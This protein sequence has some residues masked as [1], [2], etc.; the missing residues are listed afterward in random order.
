[1]PWNDRTKRRLKLRDLDILMA[2]IN[3]GS[4][5]KA[6]DRLNLSQPAVSKAMAELEAAVGVQLLD[7]S[8]RGVV[9]TTFGVAL[10]KRSIA[11]FNDLRQGVQEIDFLSDPTKG[12]EI[13]IGTTDPIMAAIVSPVIDRL[14]RKY[15]QMFFHIV[16]GDTATLYRDVTERHIEVA[17]CRMIGRLPDELAAEI[18]FYD[19]VAVMT[20]AKNPLTRRR[21]LTLADLAGEPWVLY[22]Y[23]SFFGAVIA[24]IFRANGHE[25]PR[26]RVSSSSNFVQDELLATGRFLAVLPGFMLKVPGRHPRLKALHVKLPNPRM[27]IALITLKDRMLTP[28]AQLFI[29]RVRAVTKPMA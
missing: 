15:P 18:L 10:G 3:T 25:P 21:N 11:I 22:P 4:M 2:I 5:G 28:L 27:P 12:G 29:E 19:S 7:R 9:P 26:P 17:I 20:A 8:R 14:S 24:E 23:D 13:R 6:A 1:M 16:P